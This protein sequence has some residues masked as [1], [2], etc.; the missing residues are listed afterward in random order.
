MHGFW[1][2][3][4]IDCLFNSLFRL[5]TETT[6]TLCITSLCERK[7]PM[8][9]GFHSQRASNAKSGSM[10]CSLYDLLIYFDGLTSSTGTV[11]YRY[12]AVNYLTDVKKRH[13]T[14]L[15]L[16]RSMVFFLCAQTLIHIWLQSL[17]WCMQNYVTLDGVITA[18]DCI[19]MHIHLFVHTS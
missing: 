11:R 18:L 14:T 7:P 15:P 3:W 16:G 10:P 12:N 1:T 17:Q 6:Y 5:T 8:T 2:H 9:G 13:T 19:T 4:E